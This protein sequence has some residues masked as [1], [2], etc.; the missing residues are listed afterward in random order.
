MFLNKAYKNGNPL[1]LDNLLGFFHLHK[2]FFVISDRDLNDIVKEE[3]D[4][5]NMGGVPFEIIEDNGSLYLSP[6]IG[7]SEDELCSD[8]NPDLMVILRNTNL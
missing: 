7:V 4:I 2:D 3:L 1:K 8:A 6:Y 5:A